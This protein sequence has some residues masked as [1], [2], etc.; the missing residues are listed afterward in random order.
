MI[1]GASR[2][3]RPQGTAEQFGILR[4]PQ[5]SPYPKTSS[6]ASSSL[7]NPSCDAT[8]MRQ[9]LDPHMI[10]E[11]LL[12]LVLHRHIWLCSARSSAD[13]MPAMRVHAESDART[14]RSSTCEVE[15][16][17]S[18]SCLPHLSGARVTQRTSKATPRLAKGIATA[19]YVGRNGVWCG[20]GSQCM[21]LLR[22]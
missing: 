7:C 11:Q 8:P 17:I 2:V 3:T 6:N 15:A 14:D 1:R 9:S 4:T 5:F 20:G 13:P 19:A 22:G 12:C 18:A 21:W 10:S 16:K